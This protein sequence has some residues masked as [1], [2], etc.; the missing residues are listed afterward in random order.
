MATI[1]AVLKTPSTTSERINATDTADD[2]TD[3]LTAKYVNNSTTHIATVKPTAI[4]LSRLAMASILDPMD[5]VAEPSALDFTDPAICSPPPGP[6][7][8]SK[9]FPNPLLPTVNKS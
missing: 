7:R 1:E 9:P 5:P 6:T 3:G 2:G 4:I 8:W